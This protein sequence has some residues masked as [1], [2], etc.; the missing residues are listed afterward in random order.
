[1]LLRRI[2]RTT[3]RRSESSTQEEIRE[4]SQVLPWL[5]EHAGSILCRCQKGRDG[6]IPF[7]RLHGKKPP[8]EFVP[9]G[10]KV[11][12]RQISTETMNRRH[13][14]YKFGIWLEL[15]NNSAECFVGDAEGVFGTRHKSMCDKEAVN[16]AIGVPWR[17][18]DGRWT[19][20]R[21]EVRVHSI[22]IAIAIFRN[23]NS[24]GKNHKA[25]HW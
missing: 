6:R 2:I 12:V 1:M 21:P 4:D 18:T 13:P 23:P 8:Q 15:R 10:D 3:E 25:R 20:D 9:F 5:V 17:L 24:E 7:E 14:R 22:L 16:S 19:V 11:L